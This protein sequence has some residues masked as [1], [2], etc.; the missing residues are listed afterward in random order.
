MQDRD[1]NKRTQTDDDDDDGGKCAFLDTKYNWLIVI[2][3]CQ[4]YGSGS[5]FNGEGPA[6]WLHS[7]HLPPSNGVQSW[8][9]GGRAHTPPDR[10]ALGCP[11][12]ADGGHHS[13]PAFRPLRWW[14]VGGLCGDLKWG[15]LTEGDGRLG[16]KLMEQW[17]WLDRASE[18][19][20]RPLPAYSCTLLISAKERHYVYT[21]FLVN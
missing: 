19:K 13:A 12:T 17:K 9:L 18:R 11:V 21:C 20:W 1:L 8:S 2:S 16:T 6:N 3:C 15:Q 10:S 7:I 5:W 14:D 4:R